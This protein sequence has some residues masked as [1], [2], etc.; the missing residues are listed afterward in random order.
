MVVAIG[1]VS[2]MIIL[3]TLVTVMEMN[4]SKTAS[5]DRSLTEA[6]NLAQA[7]VDN[8]IS[9]TLANFYSIYPGG[10]LPSTE[11]PFYDNDQNL[12]DS[13][14]VTIGTYQVWTRADP[15]IPGNVLVKSQG[16]V[17]GSSNPYSA[18]V[19]V[20]VKY[21]PANF[22]YALLS[23]T[24]TLDSNTT[25]TT[26]MGGE[27]D[28][29]HGGANIIVTGKVNV[30]GNLIMNTERNGSSGTDRDDDHHGYDGSDDEHEGNFG[31]VT[32]L[33]RPGF[34]DPV[35]YT[36]TIT[37]TA[38]AG[39]QPAYSN[40]SVSF[41]TI[42]F[43]LFPGS[44]Y[45]GNA[46]GVT[47]VVLPAAGVPAG[48]WTR[49]GLIFTISADDFQRTYGS[50]K[51][52]SLSSA[53]ND[54]VIQ[55][56]AGCGSSDI[57]S[58]IMVKG[59]PGVSNTGIKELDLTGPGLSLHPTNGLAILSGRGKVSL[60]NEMVVGSSTAGALIYLSGQNGASSFDASGGMVMYGSLVVNGPVNINAQGGWSHE[61]DDE[62]DDEHE[63]GS[64][65]CGGGD[66]IE[67]WD[68]GHTTNVT[69]TF[70]GSYLTNANL[71]LN[72]WTWTG[73]NGF[74]AVKD[75]YVRD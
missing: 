27:H 50:Y 8:A 34:T 23:G 58:T 16:T 74:T 41:P 25:F 63:H 19:R 20:S 36:K 38:A 1:A 29:A 26:S 57:T 69:L 7:G 54:V 4:T 22:D 62:D 68:R 14:G 55:I 73:G 37:G 15:D 48:G 66:D 42:D 2:I 30:N 71:P 64:G 31:T 24:P 32:F 47:N 21:I 51:V 10:I 75:N 11:T 49:S 5:N 59:V 43:N 56:I 17:G 65:R 60:Q 52:V 3:G 18:T 9:V 12:T 53:Q 61:D 33:S 13:N 45:P 67:H 28:D 70:E 39:N 40:T 6:S 44:P 46:N 35:N 72:W